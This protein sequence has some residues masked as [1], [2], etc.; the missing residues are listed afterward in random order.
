MFNLLLPS[1]KATLYREYMLRVV[2]VATGAF[3]TVVT[4]GIV[5]LFPSYVWL[6]MNEGAIFEKRAVTQKA[7]PVN[8]ELATTVNDAKQTIAILNTKKQISFRELIENV[9]KERGAGIKLSSIE[10]VIT[11]GKLTLKLSGISAD[12]ESLV[13]FSKALS[14]DP[15]YATVNVPISNY[16]KD[17][18]IEFSLSI[19]G[20]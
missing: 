1:D 2:I 8:E 18:N 16:V 5:F 4:I 17:R 9:I 14:K 10:Y 6:R 7:A 11:E 15:A 3:L 20:K 13:A 19:E 12:R